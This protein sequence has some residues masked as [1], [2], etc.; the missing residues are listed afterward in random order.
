V[1]KFIESVHK[2]VVTP[3]PETHLLRRAA[4]TPARVDPDRL[5]VP[6]QLPAAI[7]EAHAATLADAAFSFKNAAGN[8]AVTQPPPATDGSDEFNFFSD[9]GD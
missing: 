1:K 3:D 5:E 8:I 6:A 4:M 9:Q 7:A 2:T